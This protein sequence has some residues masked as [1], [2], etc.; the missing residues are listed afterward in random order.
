MNHKNLLETRRKLH[1]L[2]KLIKLVSIQLNVLIDARPSWI[3]DGYD[4]DVSIG[5]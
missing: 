2:D 1:F 5:R 3:I 4:S